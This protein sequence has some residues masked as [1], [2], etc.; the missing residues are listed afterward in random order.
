MSDRGLTHV[1]FVVGDLDASIAFYGTYAAM[2]PV[3]QRTEPGTGA[4][5]AW[6]TDGTRPFVLVLIEAPAFVP[7][8]R[9][10][11][12]VVSRLLPP[13]S[14][15]GVACDSREDIDALCARARDAGV[16]C[17]GPKDMEPPVGYVAFLHDPDGNVLELSFG[18]EVA[19][20]VDQSEV[21]DNG[22][23]D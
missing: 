19:F 17:S 2:K 23:G 6:V 15:L 3:H 8:R 5:V 20:T 4:R 7:R 16:R 11:S 18:Q 21:L 10:L 22:G 14:H 12:R 1:A 13:F 9:L